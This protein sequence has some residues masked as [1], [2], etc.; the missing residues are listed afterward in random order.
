MNDNQKRA[1]KFGGIGAATG[2]ATYALL[3]G[4]GLAIGGTAFAITAPI[5]VAVGAVSGLAAYG[6]S[7]AVEKKKENGNE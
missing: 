7:K 6:V 3:G 1:F 5:F 4:A 2:G